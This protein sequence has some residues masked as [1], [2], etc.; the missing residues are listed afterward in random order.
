MTNDDNLRC[1]IGV[2]GV[3]MT[4]FEFFLMFSDILANLSVYVL[5]LHSGIQ[6]GFSSW[7]EIG[8]WCKCFEWWFGPFHGNY[9]LHLVFFGRFSLEF[10]HNYEIFKTFL[11]PFLTNLGGNF[12]E[13]IIIDIFCGI[14]DRFW[15]GFLLV[16]E[17]GVLNDV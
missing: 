3:S 10:W 13:L 9:K 6:D 2:L 7:D 16:N 17:V 8:D 1:Y 15:Q 12:S 5:D 14:Q 11:F 4:S